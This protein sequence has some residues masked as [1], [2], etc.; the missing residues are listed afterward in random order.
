[1][2][3]KG[4]VIF[5]KNGKEYKVRDKRLLKFS[6]LGFYR[7]N[8][9]DTILRILIDDSI[10]SIHFENCDFDVPNKVDSIN[11][12]G[13]CDVSVKDVNFKR[14]VTFKF[15]TMD[16]SVM[17]NRSV[18]INN[19]SGASDV[20]IIGGRNACI[21]A[22]REQWYVIGGS[23]N[24]SIDNVSDSHLTIEDAKE[25]SIRN[26]ISSYQDRSIILS[27]QE[28]VELIN[29]SGKYLRIRIDSP[30][31]NYKN[32]QVESNFL[33][34]P[35]L[36]GDNDIH[37]DE[38]I[39]DKKLAKMEPFHDVAETSGNTV[40]QDNQEKI[41]DL[42]AKLATLKQAKARA[43]ESVTT[44]YEKKPVGEYVKRKI[45]NIV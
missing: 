45:D 32:V 8:K 36:F 39:D 21:N 31:F 34:F 17:K 16:R 7:L 20:C 22:C 41:D 30:V 18:Y 38:Y 27:A 24:V 23:E 10:D 5:T 29:V 43:I 9:K 6:K 1:M 19:L 33:S 35:M 12:Y 42:E 2:D 25:I 13:Y 26:C 14:S 15:D 4:Y 40:E 37:I 11:F 3:K 44:E 28:K